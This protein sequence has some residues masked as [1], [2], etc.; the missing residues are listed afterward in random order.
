MRKN[1]S[2]DIPLKIKKKIEFALLNRTNKPAVS[3]TMKASVGMNSTIMLKNQ[4][5]ADAMAIPLSVRTSPQYKYT[6]TAVVNQKE[7][8]NISMIIEERIFE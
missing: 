1:P 8:V 3:L 5:T 4:C 2:I 6:V 7:I